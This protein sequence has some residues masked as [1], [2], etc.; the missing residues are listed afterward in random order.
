MKIEMKQKRLIN[1]LLWTLGICVIAALFITVPSMANA[2]RANAHK[3]NAPLAASSDTIFNY[4]NHLSV[5]GQPANGLYDLTF[6]LYDAAANGNQLGDVQVKQAVPVTD[7]AFA[8]SLNLDA[9]SD[10][11]HYLEVRVR[12][13]GTNDTSTTLSP[14]QAIAASI[15]DRHTPMAVMAAAVP[16]SWKL[17]VTSEI[18]PTYSAIIGRAASKAA[19]F[20]SNRGTEDIYYIFP[21][22]GTQRTVQAAKFHILSRTGAYTGSAT[23]TMEILDYDGTMRHTVNAIGIDVEATTPGVW[24]DITL[25]GVSANLEVMPGE[26]LA[27]HFNLDGLPAGDLDVH[28]IFEVQVQ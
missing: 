6:A 10:G 12:P 13:S 23:L 18:T 20:R 9:P 19:S 27:F 21:A 2:Q 8:V 11:P 24:T 25:S 15:T 4:Q 3:A 22:S 16:E 26:F 28:P 1:A 7:G 14:R 17:G 5:R